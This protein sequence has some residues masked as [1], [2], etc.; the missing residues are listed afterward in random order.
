MTLATSVDV[1]TA[2]T[3]EKSP[4]AFRTI[5]EVSTALDIPAHV[6]RFWESKFSQIKPV[7]RGGGRRYYRP[8]DVNLLRGIR[9]LLKA[10]GLTIKGVQKVL[11][12]RG[13]RYVSGLGTQQS[14]E[15]VV[16]KTVPPPITAPAPTAEPVR[17]AFTEE[18]GDLFGTPQPT[19]IAVPDRRRLKAILGELQ[20]LRDAMKAQDW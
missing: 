11:K 2:L 13:V 6:L 19:P 17:A 4:D 9:D 18:Q 14:P 7:K 15:V 1:V 20:A 16:E 5:S 12:D 10:D 3:T 8:Q